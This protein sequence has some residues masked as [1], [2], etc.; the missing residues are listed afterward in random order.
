VQRLLPR[1]ESPPGLTF[2]LGEARLSGRRSVPHPDPEHAKTHAPAGGG[3]EGTGPGGLSER[4]SRGA[5]RRRRAG[6]VHS[7]KTW[8]YLFV[9][10]ATSGKFYVT[11]VSQKDC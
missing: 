5:C 11:R 4:S 8:E 2:A 1:A 7:A 9:G 10:P 3:R 6:S